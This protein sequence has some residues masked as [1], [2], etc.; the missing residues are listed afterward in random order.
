MK[1]IIK[2]PQ[3][4]I[5][6][7][8]KI[9]T[10]TKGSHPRTLRGLSRSKMENTLTST[11]KRQPRKSCQ[12]KF[13]QSLFHSLRHAFQ[14][15]HT[16]VNFI[17]Q[18]LQY[19]MRPDNLWSIKNLHPKQRSEDYG[20]V[21]DSHGARTPVVGYM[22]PSSTPKQKDKFQGASECFRQPQKPKEARS[23][24]PRPLQLQKILACGRDVFNQATSVLEP[25]KR[26]QNV[27][28]MATKSCSDEISSLESKNCSKVGAKFQ[29]Q[30]RIVSNPLL[31]GILQS[32]LGKKPINKEE[33]QGFFMERALCNK[34]PERIHR[35]LPQR[36]HWQSPYERK[37]HSPSWRRHSSPADRTLRSLSERCHH[38]PSQRKSLSSSLRTYH[39]L[40]DRLH[41][42]PSR[43]SPPRP[44]RKNPRSPSRMSPHSPSR[45][46]P[47]SPS[48][49]TPRS[50]SR[51]SH[52]IPSRRHTQNPSG[53][54][55]HSRSGSSRPSTAGRSHSRRC[56]CSP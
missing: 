31:K 38:S 3:T 55:H 34:S 26:V 36:I 43:R 12:P 49:R 37:Q 17:G 8:Y 35:R 29:A 44:S 22:S 50:S 42:S 11:S 14:A 13:I 47:L 52:H 56:P 54:S 32:H 48:R 30:E 24:L 20:L 2:G 33:Q 18:K 1:K 21:G 16:T 45:R 23:L 25:L 15:A 10:S 27:F 6:R 41:N 46:T 51:R 19:K 39:S 40:S 5:T 53:S 9:S 28:S 4:Q 7:L